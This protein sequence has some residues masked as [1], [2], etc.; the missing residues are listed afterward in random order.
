[1]DSKEFVRYY[2]SPVVGWLRLQVSSPGLQSIDFVSGPSA[3]NG[4]E[5]DPIM[6]ALTDEL[7]A[8]FRG[9]L[10]SFSVPLDPAEG[11]P[12]QRR[13]WH[14]LIR[15]PY[16]ETRSYAE[17][18]AAVGNPR[19]ARAV[20]LANKRNCIPIVIPCHRVIKSDGGLGGYDSGLDTKK[21]LLCLE[22]V[23]M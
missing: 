2:H 23:S 5:Q 4:S 1:M 6:T 7:D 14:E 22:G 15:I 12:F 13:V 3:I 19:G 20:G 18:A 9:K 17:V 21:A 8:Y 10:R 11:T 16:G